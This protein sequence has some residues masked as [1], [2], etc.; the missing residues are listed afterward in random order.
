[1]TLQ[2]NPKISIVT[3]TFNQA[4]FIEETLLSVKE[5]NYQNLEHIVID[6]AS[7]D[8]TVEILKRYSRQAGWEYLRWISEPDRGQSDALNKGFRGV[9]GDIVGWLNSDDR[10][11]PGCFHEVVEAFNRNIHADVLY[12][13]YVMIDQAGRPLRIRR[14]IEFSRFMLA[15]LHILYVPTTTSFFRRRIFEDGNWFDLS[16]D[17]TM[18]YEYYMQL[19]QKGYSF[20]HVPRLW[21]DLRLHPRSKSI[22]ERGRVCELHDAIATNYS[23]LLRRLHPRALQWLV[24]KSLRVVARSRRSLEKLIRGYYF[25]QFWPSWQRNGTRRRFDPP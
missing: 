21:A 10:Y 23:P 12:G 7:T 6:G 20:Q 2:I 24:L 15:Y 19:A 14:E 5:Q 8:G 18:D 4:L 11:R 1:M 17:N 3:P 25:E 16:L 9:T 22:A 13:D